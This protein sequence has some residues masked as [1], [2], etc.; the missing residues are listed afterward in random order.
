M[1]KISVTVIA[2]GFE[3]KKG[4][5]EKSAEKSGRIVVSLDDEPQKEDS[6]PPRKKTGLADIGINHDLDDTPSDNTF[7][8]DD[9]R[10][11]ISNY[12]QHNRYSYDE[13]YTKN[14]DQEKADEEKRKLIEKERKRRER[15]RGNRIKLSNPQTII[16]LEN[17]PAYL[18]RNVP[19]DDVP[20]SGEEN[21]SK[22]TISEEEDMDI[23]HG[24]NAFLH[25]NVD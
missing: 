4:T 19:L 5:Q 18:R 13:P 14:E 2:T 9:I 11:T 24:G 8:F 7:E 6:E 25:D 15:L 22:W 1:K 23:R 12:Q 10:E 16:E 20:D 21:M 17:E 3:H